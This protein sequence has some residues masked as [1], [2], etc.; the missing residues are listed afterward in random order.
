[1]PAT[2][3]EDIEVPEYVTLPLP[4][5]DAADEISVP[6]AATS[7]LTVPSDPCTPRDDPLFSVSPSSGLVTNAALASDGPEVHDDAARLDGREQ[8]VG[9]A[10]GQLRARGS[11][12]LPAMPALNTGSSEPIR[13][14]TAPA[15]VRVVPPGRA[16]ARAGGVVVVP[17][18]PDDLARRSA[19]A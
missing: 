9:G 1:M 10:A 3:G 4:V 7:G 8:G 11:P 13:T 2:C 6:G 14:P 5:L 19:A 17:V 15:A 18:E 16:A 12:A